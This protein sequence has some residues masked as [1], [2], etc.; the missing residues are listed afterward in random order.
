MSKKISKI[1][2]FNCQTIVTL[3][4]SVSDKRYLILDLWEDIRT[5][6]TSNTSKESVS[7]R[8]IDHNRY[9]QIFLQINDLKVLNHSDG[10]V[11]FDLT[12]RDDVIDAIT[13]L[14]VKTIQILKNYLASINKKGKFNFRSIIKDDRYDNDQGNIVLALNLVNQDYDVTFYDIAKKRANCSLINKQ[15]ACFN[16]ILEL[17]YINFDMQKGEIVADTRLRMCVETRVKMTD[18]SLFIQDDTKTIDFD[19]KNENNQKHQNT[20]S[21]KQSFDITQTEVFEET[22]GKTKSKVSDTVPD[23]AS[24]QSTRS[25]KGS[26]TALTQI[27]NNMEHLNTQS[28]DILDEILTPLKVSNKSKQFDS[29]LSPK[30]DTMFNLLS[31]TS[32]KSKPV[33]KKETNDKISKSVQTTDIPH[34]SLKITSETTDSD[35]SRF[36]SK[37]GALSLLSDVQNPT[38]KDNDLTQDSDNES[39]S[40]CIPKDQTVEAN[41]DNE[42][43]EFSD[44][45]EGYE[46]Q[47]ELHSD[48]HDDREKEKDNRADYDAEQSEDMVE[49]LDV[50]DHDDADDQQPENIDESNDDEP[51]ATDTAQDDN[52]DFDDITSDDSDI[53]TNLNNI[54]KQTELLRKAK[55]ESM[56]ISLKNSTLRQVDTNSKNLR[57]GTKNEADKEVITHN[58]SKQSKIPDLKPLSTATKHVRIQ[59]SGKNN[60]SAKS[61]GKTEKIIQLSDD[62]SSDT[63]AE[64]IIKSLLKKNIEKKKIEKKK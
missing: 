48:E 43:K 60:A 49:S 39:V 36:D 62:V 1:E 37:S 59:E 52:D 13:S 55:N 27:N 8:N 20:E 21:I 42:E 23:T 25:V 12:D 3:N 58:N 19:T 40:H 16:V 26:D 63:D 38:L 2:K 51:I 30:N 18:V 24:T 46:S 29:D 10:R 28:L 50:S 47:K 15:C 11:Y 45:S 53:M 33:Q 4:Q 9:N 54:Y 61:V 17:M 41:H 35:K 34:P 7:Q 22:H 57:E 32:T 31:N 56:D 5:G 6:T 44:S 14:E 64:D